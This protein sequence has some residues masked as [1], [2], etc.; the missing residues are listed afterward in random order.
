MKRKCAADLT[1]IFLIVLWTFTLTHISDNTSG[2]L[3]AIVVLLSI[4]VI[5]LFWDVFF[6]KGM[7][8]KKVKNSEEKSTK[9]DMMMQF[10]NYTCP[11]C[12]KQFGAFCG[13][14]N[15][16][17]Y[18]LHNFVDWS[19]VDGT[20]PEC[21]A[22]VTTTNRIIKNVIDNNYSKE[23]LDRLNHHINWIIAVKEG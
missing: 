4:I 3:I 17:D 6:P 19:S 7:S 1:L 13:P 23:S 15:P 21:D 8:R 2:W 9:D 16:D 18:G 14:A 5:G 10:N 12:G 22:L 20:C 11:Y